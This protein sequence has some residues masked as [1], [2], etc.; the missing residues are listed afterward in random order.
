MVIIEFV[1]MHTKIP[2]GCWGQVFGVA[3][4]I[5]NDTIVKLKKNYNW[6]ILKLN[7]EF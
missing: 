3:F 2:C 6:P 4:F 1:F 5:Y 7:Y